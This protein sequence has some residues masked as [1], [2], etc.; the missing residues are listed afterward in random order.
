M[1][2]SPRYPSITSPFRS[3]LSRFFETV[4][5]GKG[6][7]RPLSGRG[8]LRPKR[9]VILSPGAIPT[10]DIYLT[11]RFRGNFVDTVRTVDTLLQRPAAVVVG[12]TP[13]MIVV[14]RY[15]PLPWLRWVARRQAAGDFVVYFMDDD[16][17]MT[18]RS[19]E[20]PFS[21]AVKTGWRYAM[22]KR[23]LCRHCNEIWLSTAALARRY[24]ESAAR[25]IEPVFMVPGETNTNGPV[26]FY[27]GTRAHRWEMQWLVP[28]VKA[29]QQESPHAWFEIMGNH[30]VRRLFKGIPRV[31]VI[32]PM[33]WP[34][35]LEYTGCCRFQVGLAPCM[36][37]SFNRGRSHTKVFDITRMGAA[38]IYSS[39]IVYGNT[40]VHG[41]TGLLCRNHQKRWVAAI[42]L[43]FADPSLRDRLYRGALEWCEER[44]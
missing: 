2:L 16:M 23:S 6:L 8:D 12:E 11:K 42:L 38:G 43:L 7:L 37:T 10:T 21:Y 4:A 14:V 35:Y 22:T 33:P 39:G 29:V 20:L 19:P 27:H 25:V 17:P 44:Q 34:D 5:G 1:P 31:R 36:D 26:Y 3:L 41:Q 13:I 15:A 30:R 18:T 32:H 40:V 28:V 24:P 9:V